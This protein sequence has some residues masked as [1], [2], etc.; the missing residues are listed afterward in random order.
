MSDARRDASGISW[1]PR[2]WGI[3]IYIVASVVAAIVVFVLFGKQ[4]LLGVRDPYGFGLMGQSIQEGNSF[5]GFGSLLH[6]RSPLYPIVVGAVAWALGPNL[7]SILV[8]LYTLPVW[9]PGRFGQ[10]PTMLNAA[11]RP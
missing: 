1:S 3:T 10:Q 9:L 4:S 5:Q 7:R 6:R 8:L 2:R 11:C